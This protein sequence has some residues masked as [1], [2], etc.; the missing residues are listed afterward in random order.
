ME[1][2]PRNANINKGNPGSFNIE[3]P[4]SIIL[5]NFAFSADSA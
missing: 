5:K 3:T 1:E 4:K 2:N